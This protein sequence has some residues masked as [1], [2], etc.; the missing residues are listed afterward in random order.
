MISSAQ[1]Q[2]DTLTRVFDSIS[3]ISASAD[4][5]QVSNFIAELQ[6]LLDRFRMQSGTSGSGT[7]NVSQRN[8]SA[9]SGSAVPNKLI[10]LPPS[11]GTLSGSPLEQAAP[12]PSVPVVL[13]TPTAPE[14]YAK[15][16]R[17]AVDAALVRL[18]LDPSHFQM[19]F[20]E[21][22]VTYPGGS[23]L[24]RCITVQ[25][26]QGYKMDF[27]AAAA[28]RTPQVTAQEIK[29]LSEGYYEA[30]AAISGGFAP[31]FRS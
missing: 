17:A 31:D 5:R 11:G 1:I 16:C 28:L 22:V 2:S 30:P 7:Q 12:G 3:S 15:E 25:T 29:F 13:A 10:P 21:E 14:S 4:S 20:W 18:G 26:P 23:Y 27:D 6:A 24:N 19:S 9:T 8:S